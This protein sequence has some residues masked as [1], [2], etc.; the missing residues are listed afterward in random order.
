MRRCLDRRLWAELE[1]RRDRVAEAVRLAGWAGCPVAVQI[2]GSH[3]DT[4]LDSLAAWFEARAAQ[5]W[6]REPKQ[7]RAPRQ[8]KS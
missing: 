6:P 8:A 1:A 4:I 2:V 3:P 7:G 5:P